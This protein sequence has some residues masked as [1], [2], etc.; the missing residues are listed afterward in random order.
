MNKLSTDSARSANSL[1]KRLTSVA[2]PVVIPLA[3]ALPSAPT[4]SKQSAATVTSPSASSGKASHIMLSYCWRSDA[5]PGHVKKLGA[6][7]KNMG[8]DVW[9]DEVLSNKE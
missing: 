7:L 1:V 5:K 2:D 6:A 9:R 4:P 3:T 8:Y